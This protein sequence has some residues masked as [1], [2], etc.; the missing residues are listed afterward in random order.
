MQYYECGFKLALRE[1]TTV[2]LKRH[3]ISSVCRYWTVGL[4][5]IGISGS[6]VSIAATSVVIDSGT[7]AILL[8]PEDSQAIHAVCPLP[9]AKSP[10]V[11]VSWVGHDT[12][13]TQAVRP[14]P[15]SV[16]AVMGKVHQDESAQVTCGFIIV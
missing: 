10:H 2:Q 4:D 7:S 1:V 12:A 9:W 13:T 3:S 15:V 8:G 14:E 11:M 16:L 6:P 5:G